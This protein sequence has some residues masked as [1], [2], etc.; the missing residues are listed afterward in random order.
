MFKK[1]FYLFSF[2]TL[3][4]IQSCKSPVSPEES[5]QKGSIQFSFSSGVQSSVNSKS[6][7]K[8]TSSLSILVTL[9]NSNGEEVFKLR[10]MD[11]ISFG[12]GQ[13]TSPI[14]LKVGSYHV[15]EFVVINEN[16]EAVYATPVLGS[17]LA[18]VV[19]KPLP[20]EFSV[21]KD[22]VNNL[23][24]EVVEIGNGNPEDFGYASFKFEIIPVINFLLTVSVYNSDIQGFVL[25]DAGLKVVNETSVLFDSN[26]NAATNSI[27]IKD[28]GLDKIYKITVKKS[29]YKS[30]VKELNYDQLTGYKNK[31]I[32]FVLEE[33][34]DVPESTLSDG[35][36]VYFPFNGNANDESG[37]NF[38]GEVNGASIS[39]DRKGESGKAFEFDGVN[40]FIK[41]S[42]IGNSIPSKEISVSIWLKSKSSKPQFQ[43]ML[44][45]DNNR[46][47]VSV[48]YFHDGSNFAFWDFGWQGE[49]GNAP[50]RLYERNHLLNEIWHHFVFISSTSESSMKIY[51]DGILLVSESDPRSLLNNA[52]KDL[53]IGSGDNAYF[54]GG[55]LDDIRIY[56]RVITESEINQLYN[57]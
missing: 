26:I 22:Q 23:T 20:V 47:A 17:P 15:T 32:I 25:T 18:H 11:L 24:L 5:N 51:K 12:T 27:V 34:N 41:V 2:A 1:I 56:N 19:S 53:R 48:D 7:N 43:L 54:Y 6:L 35:L 39:T 28:L 29:G 4:F 9:T 52:G 8:T 42:G 13:I 21:E 30:Q 37:N 49:G 16:N 50:G 45:P 33:G 36:V 40:D 44:T 46:F 38:N 14:D 57:E 10:K 55:W 31:P 3:F